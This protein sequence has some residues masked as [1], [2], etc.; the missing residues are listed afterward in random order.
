[1]KVSFKLDYQTVWGENL[2]IGG[3]SPKFGAVVKPKGDPNVK[4]RES[5]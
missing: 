3:S 5:D 2:H 1:M 4:K